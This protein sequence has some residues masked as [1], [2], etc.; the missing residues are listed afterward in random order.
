MHSARLVR[1]AP[2]PGP[3]DQSVLLARP[4]PFVVSSMAPFLTDAGFASL[5]LTSM[6][7]LPVLA[8]R[9]S[10]AVISLA[11]VS[12]LAATPGEVFTALRRAA[13]TLPVIFAALISFERAEPLLSQIARQ[14]GVKASLAEAG[15]PDHEGALGHP[16]TFVYL[17]K[18]DLEDAARRRQALSVVRRHLAKPTRRGTAA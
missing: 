8:S 12:E 18:E 1:S 6:A 10:G 7:D 15:A 17:A 13:P 9:A 4:H 2:F 5:R 11:L 16:D 3:M 14:A